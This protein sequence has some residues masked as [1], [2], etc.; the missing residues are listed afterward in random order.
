MQL[1]GILVATAP[2][3]VALGYVCERDRKLGGD[4]IERVLGGR[5][6]ELALEQR[7]LG[8]ILVGFAEVQ[9]LRGI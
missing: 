5:E 2:V 9:A 8:R 6:A 1:A 3:P 7:G 4:L